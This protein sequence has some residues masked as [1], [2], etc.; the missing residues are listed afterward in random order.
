MRFVFSIAPDTAP[1]WNGPVFTKLPELVF[2][3]IGGVIAVFNTAIFASSRTFL[4][5][6]IHPGQ[7][8][9][10]FGVYALS[11]TATVWLGPL[12]VQT[13]VSTFESQQAGNVAIAIL[14]GLG[15]IPL[16]LVKDPARHR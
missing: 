5:H 8:G 4:T 7:S 12:M 9:A 2:L 6:L 11:G 14:L 16:S 15:L 13:A 3:A 1:L 10:F